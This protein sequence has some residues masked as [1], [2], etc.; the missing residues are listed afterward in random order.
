[1]LI[2][3]VVIATQYATTKIP[4]SFGI[5]HPS[6]ADIRFVGADNSSADEPR[7]LRILDNSSGS[8][9]YQLMLGNH[10][11]GN[12]KNYTAAFAIVNEEQF[13][14]NIT[15]I[16][17]SGNGSSFLSVWLHG[18][19]TTEAALEESSARIQMVDNGVSLTDA[20]T[21]AWILAAGNGDPSNMNGT[22]IETG[23]DETAH[24][25]YNDTTMVFS[26]NT[27]RD[28]I[29]VQI[30][31]FIPIGTEIMPPYEGSIWIHFKA[32]THA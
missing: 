7:A 32:S 19:H 31:I 13:P 9:Y 8:Q 4:Y 23:W 2:L 28:W 15:Y 18:N 10:S 16:N 27:S 1:M 29:W 12:V 17:V 3:S 6:N 20:N 21:N 22:V 26:R 30:S 5:V 14:I 24:V 11:L 25:R